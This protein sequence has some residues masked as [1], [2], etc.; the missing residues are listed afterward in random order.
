MNEKLNPLKVAAERLGVS[1]FTI[2]SYHS[3]SEKLK[4]CGSNGTRILFWDA[5]S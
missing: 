4:A 1:I 3:F 5:I 2:R